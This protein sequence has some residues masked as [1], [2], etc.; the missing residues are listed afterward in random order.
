MAPLDYLRHIG[1]NVSN[2][3][4]QLAYYQTYGLSTDFTGTR[5]RKVNDDAYRF[6]VR[7][8]VPSVADAVGILHKRHM[9]ADI[10]TP[11]A[12]ELRGEI[13]TM[14][15]ANNWAAYRHPPGFGAHMLAGFIFI[16]PRVGPFRMCAV[17]GPGPQAEADYVHSVVLSVATMR[18][19]LARF[20]P[21]DKRRSPPPVPPGAQKPSSELA[22]SARAESVAQRSDPNHTLADRDLD[23]GDV[24]KPGGYSLTDKTYAALLHTLTS[25]PKVPIPEGIKEDIQAYYANLDAPITTKKHPEQW[26]Q[27]LAD[28]QTLK[29]MPT[30]PYPEPYPTFEEVAGRE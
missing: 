25:Q 15:V 20:T 3:Q 29:D 6:A 18:Q 22:T 11:E 5:K 8:F 28:L 4:L 7:S 12:R 2:R 21:P 14:A 23:T 10:D 30:S 26:K 13:A 19:I 16:M 1:M 17:K 9:A 27:V 24:V